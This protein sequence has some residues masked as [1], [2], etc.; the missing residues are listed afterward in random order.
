MALS[1]FDAS[2]AEVWG[3]VDVMR[4][5]DGWQLLEV[6]TIPGMTEYS[7]V[8]KAAAAAGISFVDLLAEIYQ[9]SLSR[10]SSKAG[11]QS[12][13]DIAERTESGEVQHGA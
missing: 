3:R 12:D 11:A 8:P 1:A 13:S 7:L 6:N 4:G 2:G 10:C 9:A 5:E